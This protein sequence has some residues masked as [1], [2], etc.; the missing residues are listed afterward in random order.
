MELRK[1][2]W[3]IEVV[4]ESFIDFGLKKVVG[5]QKIA[6]LSQILDFFDESEPLV[7][8]LNK[9][10]SREVEKVGILCLEIEISQ[11]E[12]RKAF[13]LEVCDGVDIS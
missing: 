4:G 7:F 12:R 2:F 5:R 13:G 11:V 9:G 6:L 3:R 10:V 1:E 8:G